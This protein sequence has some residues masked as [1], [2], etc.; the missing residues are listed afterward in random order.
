MSSHS[1]VVPRMSWVRRTS[2]SVGLAGPMLVAPAAVVHGGGI[3]Q[4][5]DLGII[6]GYAQAI[7]DQGQIVGFAEV[8]AGA[9]EWDAGLVSAL[10]F[11]SANDIND[12]GQVVGYRVP[13]P[14][15]G[16]P[17]PVVWDGGVVADLAATGLA[18]AINEAGQVV[19]SRTGVLPDSEQSPVLWQNGA[20][21]DLPIPFEDSYGGFATGI[22]ELGE[23]A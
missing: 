17:I 5:T 8:P 18:A 20:V 10:G 11:D 12:A 6:G 16:S 15:A 1:A 14:K 21:V 9:F 13:D 7:D 4:L 3:A 22:N 19:G 23:I 2:L